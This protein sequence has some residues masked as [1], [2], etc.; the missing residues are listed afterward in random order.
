MAVTNAQRIQLAMQLLAQGLG[1]FVD[2]RL[3]KRRGPNWPSALGN[4]QRLPAN[5]KNDA[6]FLLK[7]MIAEWRDVFSE[8]LG[9]S[10]RSW[11]GELLDI[12]NRWAHNEA[13]STE[14]AYRALDTAQ[15]L[16]NAV[17]AGQQAVE[18]D[19]MRQQL[20]QTRSAEE[21]RTV[22]RRAATSA[23]EGQPAAG[24]KPWREVVVP[25]PDVASGRYQQAEFAADLYQVWKGEA[26]D[27]YGKPE[28]FFRRTYLT[29][30]LRDLLLSATRRLRGEAGDP[31]VALQTNFGG[32]KTHSLIAL[33][34]LAAG[35]GPSQ[36]PGVEAMLA[37][38]GLGAPPRAATAVL[39]GQMLSPSRVDTKSDGTEVRTLW[40]ELAWQLGGRT[41]FEEVAGPTNPG[42]RLIA[43]LRAHAPCL[44]LIDEWVAYARQLYGQ[45]GLPAGSFDAQFTFAQALTD[46]ARNVPNAMLVVSIPASDI[47]TGGEAGRQA[48]AR[49]ENLIGR[50]ETSWKPATADEGFEIVRRRLFEDVPPEAVRERDAVVRAFGDL[51]RAQRGE[52]PA[53]CGEMDYERR[54]TASYP[55]H[56]ELFDRLYG[57]WSTLERF[58]R[59]RGVL[60]LMAAVIHELWE[61]DDRSLLILPGTMPI[62]ASAV[63]SELTRYLDEG[64]T[65]VISSDVDGENSLPLRL[66]RENPGTFG[67]YSA[68]RRVG[69]TV[70]MGSAP[71]AEAANRGIDDRRIKL[72]CVQPGESPATF[73]DALR[74]LSQQATYL[75][76]DGRRYWYSLQQTVARLAADRANLVPGDEVDE[77][78]RRRLR[79]DRERGDFAGVH[80]A[81]SSP[82]DVPDEPEARLVVIDP[83][84]AHTPKTKD[85]AARGFAERMLEE[86][87]AGPRLNKNMLVFLAPDAT[88][89]EE[90]RE[91]VRQ[92]LAWQ[93]IA[94]EE[95]ALNL[96]GV[97]RAQVR[98]RV[99]EGDATVTQRI[100]ETY[101][102]LMTPSGRAGE[103][104]VEWSETRVGGSD[105]LAVRVSKK[106]RIEEGLIVGYS[107]ARLRM[108]LDRVPLWR[109]D[110]VEVRQLWS[111]Y[112]Q[113]LY[114]PRLRDASVLIAAVE[115]GVSLI[116]WE[117]DGFAFADAWD[118]AEGRYVGLRCAEQMALGDLR[119]L[120]VKPEVASLQLAAEKP[121]PPAREPDPGPGPGRKPISPEPE[122]TREEDRRPRRFY[123]SV[124]LDPL[125]VGRDAAQ[126]GEAVVQH[127]S[128]LMG[129]SVKVR[130]E[131]EAEIPEG[132][133]DDVVRTV[134]ENARTLKF[135]QHGFEES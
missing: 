124:Q 131:V 106:L 111:D 71:I 132:A 130:L 104:G 41:A 110:H 49:L 28:E 117:T 95:E 120:L 125:R 15:L 57:E 123:G 26:A 11:V 7:S 102:W 14:Q 61:S 16:L 80:W 45:D 94:R 91:S 34:H 119:G 48:R 3:S 128:G 108:D 100:G 96:D 68:V 118:E 9:H 27:E 29:E 33:Y 66:D 72:G 24:L 126:I 39:V 92:L 43:L 44:I 101:A 112:A 70:Y 109:G 79:S 1:P 77:E 42:D 55:I 113:Y 56:P 90:L 83:E 81:A 89:L 37:E 116:T 54:L 127:F 38:A 114:L 86:R 60:R 107:G 74:R 20:Q 50:M 52:F 99:A 4:G 5:A 63:A 93:S 82:A 135:D 2:H 10:E 46:A 105:P 36:L 35:Y 51:Y 21:A 84:Y 59:T 19:K 47:E 97:Q 85:S 98:A 12:R 88:R 62:Y 76:S 78:V 87:A 75:N 32:G 18:V 23:T 30:G 121:E 64:W 67:R 122:Q 13:F 31:I 22:R 133:P 65:P 129:A 103:R 8:T 17:N 134:T 53:E 58:Q 6:Q 40:E 73:G 25:H 115:D 69:R